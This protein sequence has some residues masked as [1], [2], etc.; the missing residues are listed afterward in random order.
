[1]PPKD[2][3]WHLEPHSQAKHRILRGYVNAW[4]PIMTR[5]NTRVLLIDAFAGPGRYLGGEPGSPLILLDCYLRHTYR[6]KMTSEIVYFFIEERPD[7]VEHLRSEIA[8]LDIPKNVK[9]N[10]EEGRYEDIFRRGLDELQAAGKSIAP[11]FAFVDPFGYAAASMDLTGRFMQFERCEALIYM[12]LPFVSRF[13]GREGQDR[14][15]TSLFGTNEWRS[16]IPLDG[17]ERRQFLHDLFRDQLQKNGSRFVRSFEIESAQGNGYDLFYATSHKL[18]LERMKETMWSLDPAEGGRFRDTTHR[19]QLVLFQPEPDFARLREQV[20]G[21]FKQRDFT[22][23]EALDFVLFD[24]LFAPSQ[25]RRAV[26]VPAEVEGRLEVLTP[27]RRRRT[28]PAGT[29]LRFLP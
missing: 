15:M 24:T 14:A 9:V 4:L 21:A 5:Y 20:L 8:G 16:A 2:T 6:S 10:V 1:M 18:G 29:R 12:P 17:D 19:D 28:Y 3:L 22:I 23:E 11:T 7:R 25:L 27:R 26:L 13:I